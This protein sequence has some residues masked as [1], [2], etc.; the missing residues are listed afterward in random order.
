MF[1]PGCKLAKFPTN[2]VFENL[3]APFTLNL[4]ELLIAPIP[5]LSLESIKIPP[6]VE[7]L[8]ER[9]K[10]PFAEIPKYP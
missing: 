7:L 6:E 3:A 8:F 1:T 2:N 10:W 5:T 4:Y 9:N